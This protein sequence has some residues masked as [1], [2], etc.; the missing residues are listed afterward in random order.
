MANFLEYQPHL[1]YKRDLKAVLHN[2]QANEFSH[3]TGGDDDIPGSDS[4]KSPSEQLGSNGYIPSEAMKETVDLTP[5]DTLMKFAET[6][7]KITTLVDKIIRNLGKDV[8]MSPNIDDYI[9]ARG[10][11]DT[12]TI[13]AF[14][15]F[16]SDQ[17]EGST[18][19]EV[20]PI[21]FNFKEELDSLAEFM[22]EYVFSDELAQ[23]LDYLTDQIDRLRTE[24]EANIKHLIQQDLDMELDED[25]LKEKNHIFSF[26]YNRADTM[27]AFT[28]AVESLISV[29]PESIYHGTGSEIAEIAAKQSILRKEFTKLNQ[30]RFVKERYNTS[31]AAQ[32]MAR[33]TDKEYKRNLLDEATKLQAEKLESRQAISALY[34][35]NPNSEDDMLNIFLMD[36]LDGIQETKEMSDSLVE[37][38]YRITEL[39]SLQNVDYLTSLEGKDT[40]RHM[41]TIL[42]GLNN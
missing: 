22:G 36:I 7:A 15:D 24:E 12:D 25:L 37:D 9:K 11:N 23:G 19:A 10:T 2:V 39:E 6:K 30:R 13:Y 41:N 20:L 31:D 32:R 3:Y 40:C 4:Y 26:L 21:L 27:G 18:Q 16:H 1:E 38:L 8:T 29:T 5:T 17:I 35:V 33:L 14:E 42:S 28:D 34:A